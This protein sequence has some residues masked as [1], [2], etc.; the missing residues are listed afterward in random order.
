MSVGFHDCAEPGLMTT[1]PFGKD[2]YSVSV[3][4]IASAAAAPNTRKDRLDCAPDGQE[5]TVTFCWA[6][7]VGAPGAVLDAICA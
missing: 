4:T 3:R 5:M 7:T 1:G 2:K 6:V